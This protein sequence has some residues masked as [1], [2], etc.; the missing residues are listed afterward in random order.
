MIPTLWTLLYQLSCFCYISSITVTSSSIILHILVLFIY[1]IL[2]I[3]D[4]HFNYN[5]FCSV[6]LFSF[7]ASLPWR[8]MLWKK[9][10]VKIFFFFWSF[11]LPNLKLA[12]I[13]SKNYNIFSIKSEAEDLTL[14]SILNPK[15]ILYCISVF[16][17]QV[18]M[19]FTV[20][21]HYT[22]FLWVYSRHLLEY[23]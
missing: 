15:K 22:V 3:L 2:D 1:N 18:Q 14:L 4:F 10:I 17:G 21:M 12:M 6:C 13:H 16:W 7:C 9:A 8:T 5:S 20:Q 23:K 19:H 11:F